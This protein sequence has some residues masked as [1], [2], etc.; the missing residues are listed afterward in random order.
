M[1]EPETG[2]SGTGLPEVSSADACALSGPERERFFRELRP[3]VR[4]MLD[5]GLA[6]AVVLN[7]APGGSCGTPGNEVRFKNVGK[8]NLH[9]YRWVWPQPRYLII[10]EAEATPPGLLVTDATVVLEARPGTERP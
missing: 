4:I 7:G 10:A 8:H 1:T 9:V 2:S 3:N 5:G 6:G